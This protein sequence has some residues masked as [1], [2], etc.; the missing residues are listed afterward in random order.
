MTRATE[1]EEEKCWQFSYTNLANFISILLV[2]VVSF[3][4]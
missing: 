4:G 3:L 2:T 1:T